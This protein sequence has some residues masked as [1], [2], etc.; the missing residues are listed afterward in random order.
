MNWLL[1]KITNLHNTSFTFAFILIVAFSANSQSITSIS[2]T[3]GGI[4]TTVT[5]SGTGFNTTPADNTV[6][7]G[8]VKA[9]PSS[10]SANSLTVT[11]PAGATSISPIVV[12]DNTT[13]LQ[14]SSMETIT[15]STTRQF[16]V[17]NTP[18][19]LLNYART[20]IAVGNTPTWV[21]IGDFNNDGNPDFA[22][23]DR[24]DNLV[25]IRLG[26]GLGGFANAANVAVG[27][28]PT[29]IAISDFNGD[30]NV[31]LAVTNSGSD[32]VSIRLGD[33][34]GGF[35]GTTTIAV[36]NSP[37]EISVGDFNGDGNADFSTGDPFSGVS[38]R[39]GDGSGGFSGTTTF[40]AG[41]FP[42]SAVIG[43]LSGDGI[44]DLAIPNF[45]SDNVSIRIGDG[46]GGFSGTTNISVGESPTSLALGDFN[47]DGNLDFA[48]ANFDGYSVSVRLGDGS[49]GFT[50]TAD[51]PVGGGATPYPTGITIGDFNGDGYADFATSETNY[52]G[53]S[54]ALGDGTGAFSTPIAVSVGNSSTFLATGDFNRDGKADIAVSN[55]ADDDVSI[56]LWEAFPI[57]TASTTAANFTESGI[58]IIFDFDANDGD[59]GAT[60]T[61][62]TYSVLGTDATAF[63]ISAAGELTFASPPDFENP[64]DNGL[65]NIY[66]V[67]VRANN[68]TNNTDIAVAI[69]VLDGLDPFITTWVATA[70]GQITIPTFPAEFGNYTVYWENEGN[71]SDNGFLT[72]QLG[73]AVITGLTDG[74][75]YRVEITG[76]FPR[77]YFD[78]SGDRLKIRTVEQWGDNAW[79]SMAGAFYGCSQLTIPA[80]DVPDLT[81]VTDVTSMFQGCSIFNQDISN[82]DV[83][84]V[85]NMLR[86]FYE[87]T[88]FNNGGAP[89]TWATNSGTGNVTSMNSMFFGTNFNQDISSW[90]VSSVASMTAMF[91]STSAFN[92]GSAPLTWVTNGGPSNVTDMSFMFEDA[93]SFNQD[94]SSWDVSSVLNMSRMFLSASA[95]NNGGVP[96]TW[97]TNGGTGMVT[98]MS[99]MFRSASSFNQDISSWDVSSVVNMNDMFNFAAAFNNAGAPLTWSTNTGTGNVT[100]MAT[101]FYFATSFN[102]DISNW[103]VGSATNMYRMF[104]SAT[105][106]NQ[107]LGTWDVSSVVNVTATDGMIEMFTSSG[108]STANYDAILEGWSSLTLQNGVQ[109]DATGIIYCSPSAAIARA[110][111]ISTFGW[112]IND[113]GV[114]EPT[115]QTNNIVASSIGF[116]Q[117]DINWFNGNG[118]DRMMVVK[119][120]SAVATDPSDLTSYT[121]NAVFG[122]GTQIGI[123]NYVVYNSNST[124]T[125]MTLTGLTP[126]TNYQVRLYEFNGTPGTENYLTVTD[127]ANPFNFTTAVPPSFVLSTSTPSANATNVIRSTSISLDFDM[128][129]NL[130]SVNNGTTA[131]TDVYDDNITILGNLSGQIE[132]VY[133]VGA[134]N[135]IIIFNPNT[136]F[137]A[138]EKISVIIND[139]VLGLGAEV[140]VPTSFSFIAA[141]EPFQGAYLAKPS[142]GILG[143]ADGSFDWG[144]YDNDGDL[145]VLMVGY[146]ET[147]SFPVSIIYNNVNGTFTDISAG[148]EGVVTSSTDWGDYDNDGDLDLV[149]AGLDASYT[150][151]ITTIY[152]ND[153]GAFVDIGAG[154]QGV[155]YSA[156]DWGD[157]DNDGDLD[158]IVIGR[159]DVGSS[160]ASSTIYRNDGSDTFTDI[161]AGLIPLNNG[162]VDW[163]D[164][165]SDGDLD[166]VMTGFDSDWSNRITILYDNTD[167]IFTDHVVDGIPDMAWGDTDWG[168][169]DNDGDLDLLISGDG[170]V[171]TY[172]SIYNNDGSG[173]FI[174][175]GA[176]FPTTS[177]GS[178]RWGDY[179]GDGNLD[180]VI[181][182]QDY[183]TGTEITN[184]FRNNGGGVFNDINAGLQTVY[185]TGLADWG[186]F[187]GDGDL[188]LLVAGESPISPWTS[189]ILYENTVQPFITTWVTGD[190]QI[191]IPT[192]GLGFDYNIIWTNL[193]NEGVGDGAIGG[194]TGTYT[195][196]G[197][198]PGDT[199]QVSIWGSFPHIFLNNAFG[200]A[201]KLR[202]IEQ[203][204]D[205]EWQSMENSFYGARN[206]IINAQDSPDLSQVTSLRRMFQSVRDVNAFLNT[207]LSLWNVSTITDMSYM[208]YFAW[209]F[210]Q[211][212][213]N[214]D[215]SNVTTFFYTFAGTVTFNQPLEDW[216]FPNANTDMTS[217]F[218]GTQAFNQPLQNWDVSNITNM[219]YMFFE[220]G[221]YD[222]PLEGWDVSAVTDMSYMFYDATVFNQPLNGWD[223]S[224]VNNM[225]GMFNYAPAF[226][227]PIN[228]WDVSNVTSMYSMFN[229]AAAFNQSLGGWDISSVTD[230]SWMLDDAGLSTANYDAT[231]IG[232]ADD[233]GGTETIPPNI[234]LDAYLLT[235]CA[236]AS[237][238]ATLLASPYNW[239]ITDA[240]VS[241]PEINV[242]EG[243][244]NTGTAILDAQPM[245]VNFGPAVQ[246]N[247]IT[248]TFAIQNTGTSDLT[249]ID[250]S[251]SGAGY[252]V[253]S[254]ISTVGVGATETF[255][256]TLS[257]ATTGTFNATIS[258]TSDDVD[259]NPFTFDVTGVI[260]PNPL[261]E[262]DMF[263]GED[264]SGS[265]IFNGQTDI[266]EIG[267]AIQG[268]DIVQ[269]FAIQNTGDADLI[270][271]NITQSEIGYSIIS[272]ITTVASGTTETF[273]VTLSGSIIG[274][275]VTEI[276]ITSNDVDENPFTFQLTGSI[277]GVTLIDGTDTSGE[278]IISNQEVNIGSTVVNTDINKVFVIENLSTTN[279]LIINSIIS[280][281]PVFEVI[282]PP[283]T[284]APS[285]FTPFTV[286][287]I[288]NVVGTYQ[289]TLSVSTNLNDFTFIVTGEVLE[290]DRST[291]TVYNVVTPNGDGVHDYLKINNLENFLDNSVKIYNRWGDTVYEVKGYDNLNI[292]FAGVGNLGRSKDL[293]TGNYYYII[294]K[295]NGE[296]AI[297][298]F[299]FLK[300]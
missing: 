2:P 91:R 141:S 90:D 133:S 127:V 129:V 8:A 278:V 289:G 49:G 262:I 151:R 154:L 207:D 275:F 131:S 65:D 56:M 32:D 245:A 52:S 233:N 20:D 109:L 128:D 68:G 92:N 208:F 1:Q 178:V 282:D 226:N 194:I 99:F 277:E 73:D 211:D 77:I 279:D 120:G 39:L 18:T 66:D 16:T 158:L 176:G 30:G 166:L 93:T 84:S 98:N 181:T 229:F 116:S 61:G 251:S 179:D 86:M 214:W 125:T 87:A 51:I 72:A 70:D 114:C 228:D 163:G 300:R 145:D 171:L 147:Y 175:I 232:W 269:T 253:S 78:N 235:Y 97:T 220:A 295:G 236:G 95:F 156:V 284:I 150:N 283:Q 204:G 17:T 223:V 221:A 142:T 162:S 237:A 107:D 53:L 241:C 135:S 170:P 75:T 102:Q 26:D 83:S 54:I 122:S 38:I 286:R 27:T 197:L 137:L 100:N 22:T 273:S 46:A 9:T 257:G 28:Q 119:E 126:G 184:I 250:I 186:D 89:L 50:S 271:N 264:S 94:I 234:T 82:W 71:V 160:L 195:V 110:N 240:G 201:I 190:G 59:G 258:I 182:G 196:S 259:E 252:S 7:F 136:D 276:T 177:E 268:D 76:T 225:E 246:S 272:S 294:D 297:T 11:V 172:T 296:D 161:V 173:N 247:S 57:F 198:A 183:S 188:D 33:G 148:L 118:S 15:G 255:N 62:I 4:G 202:S 224:A 206:M 280:D 44:A 139:Q 216:V 263:Q 123:G 213:N 55:Y 205:I 5:I 40:T 152:R 67:T 149:I 248:R 45:F 134:D 238:H 174:D 168:D 31:D 35:S 12:Q 243:I 153:A 285:E 121:A 19:L 185:F 124:G 42:Y 10:G 144:D 299:I 47:E 113:G 292:R 242:F 106:F 130:A 165:D 63:N 23:A 167:G 3:S 200:N 270:I 266:I 256:V 164:Y 14:A 265:A 140:A 159:Y 24:F 249:I 21:A 96:L 155:D 103:D 210:N 288:A 117:I 199:Y 222:Q 212:I 293:V 138:G 274:T 108:L 29:S 227:Q 41:S 239:T 80:T 105:A 111:I 112:T 104:R 219:S 261:P 254:A 281:N 203:W 189:A 146:D 48:T 267:T 209:Y 69:T 291:I 60:D 193:D 36:G 115:V 13:G 260:T 290:G 25:S 218:D 74:A 215:V 34:L 64:T 230:M 231:L 157:Y 79:S 88:A 217:M 85:E 169:Y 37:N 132:G 187:D 287:L 6:Y 298:G 43:D 191:T 143:M 58:G 180:V 192:N 81:S 244:N 101:M